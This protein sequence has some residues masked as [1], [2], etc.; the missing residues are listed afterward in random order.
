MDEQ[1]LHGRWESEIGADYDKIVEAVGAARAKKVEPVPR[2][3]P[4]EAVRDTITRM[5]ERKAVV[6]DHEVETAVLNEANGRLCLLDVRLAMARPAHGII[7]G[8]PD[9]FGSRRITTEVALATERRVVEAARDRVGIYRPMLQPKE[10]QAVLNK[11]PERH[12]DGMAK[13]ISSRDGV[14]ILTAEED[15]RESAVEIAQKAGAVV[16]NADKLGVAELDRALAGKSRVIILATPSKS[17]S[18]VVR[19]LTRQTAC[20]HARCTTLP[21]APAWQDIRSMAENRRASAV[22]AMLEQSDRVRPER[23]AIG[24]ALENDAVL[25]IPDWAEAERLTKQIR[26]EAKLGKEAKKFKVTQQVPMDSGD[27]RKGQNYRAG[28]EL[29]NIRGLGLAAKTVKIVRQRENELE[30]ELGTGPNIVINLGHVKPHANWTAH[31]EKEIE[32]RP[33]DKLLL[34]TGERVTV[35]GFSD[36]GEP[37]TDAGFVVKMDN[38]VRHGWA[39]AETTPLKAKKIAVVGA[40]SRNGLCRAIGRGQNGAKLFTDD[41]VKFRAALFQNKKTTATSVQ[42]DVPYQREALNQQKWLVHCAPTWV[43]VREKQP[44]KTKM[45]VLGQNKAAVPTP[46]TAEK[47]RFPTRKPT[48]N[49]ERE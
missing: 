39:V 2:P 24:W 49:H 12:R 43:P 10:R 20:C 8:K 38:T 42:R 36:Q 6:T 21:E 28:M 37:I 27:K 17:P 13:L 7:F 29:R 34:K 25:V 1:R 16:M 33:G 14:V 19:L 40:K 9:R 32:V 35:E 41:V 30:V 15:I 3:N 5:T 26:L 31:V 18:G 22:L 4:Y 23:E 48:L 44:E 11:T 45:P 47:Q 46:Q